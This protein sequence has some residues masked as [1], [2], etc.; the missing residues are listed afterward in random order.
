MLQAEAAAP[1]W[2]FTHYWKL[3]LEIVCNRCNIFLSCSTPA[4]L[5]FGTCVLGKCAVHMGD[6]DWVLNLRPQLVPRGGQSLTATSSYR[7]EV[8]VRGGM[9]E[10]SEADS[11]GS[12]HNQGQKGTSRRLHTLGA[13]K[14]SVYKLILYCWTLNPVPTSGSTAGREGVWFT[15]NV[16]WWTGHSLYRRVLQQVR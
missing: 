6:H 15:T 9:I 14:H 16:Q 8:G 12:C 13:S 10:I 4:H 3:W 2:V 11:S 5:L 1:F 7:G